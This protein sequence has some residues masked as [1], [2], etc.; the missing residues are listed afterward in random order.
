MK[1]LFVCLGNICRSPGAEAALRHL[2]PDLMIDSAGTGAW[3]VGKAPY[4]PMQDAARDRGIDMSDL[5]ARVITAQDFENFDQII[6]MDAENKS[7]VEAIR[8]SR[9]TTPVGL[10]TDITG[11]SGPVPD[12]YFTRDFDGA[13]DLIQ[14][15]AA[16]LAK[17]I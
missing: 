3:H 17:Q 16:D 13:W 2:R 4:G 5:R 11:R 9:N 1:V 14:A 6:V 10:F 7:D 8:P 12:P 15:C